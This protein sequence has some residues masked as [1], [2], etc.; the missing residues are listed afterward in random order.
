MKKIYSILIMSILLSACGTSS[1]VQQ[2]K[3]PETPNFQANKVLVI[4]MGSDAVLRR[5]FEGKLV[6]ALEKKGVIAVKSVDFF[7][8]SFT[9]LKQSEAQLNEIENTLMDAGFDAVLFSKV[10]G[11]ESK[12]S[13]V[14][15]YHNFAKSFE[16][17][18]DYYYNNQQIYQKEQSPEYRIYNTETSLYCICPGKERELLWRGQIDIVAPTKAQKSI[19]D[20]I[21][22]LLSAL[23]E[24]HILIIP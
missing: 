9:N 12:V 19:R 18:R 20:Y 15:S 5:E 13:M 17:F 7:P 11:Q 1:L 6:E 8:S 3:S 10:T 16:S 2:W 4:G 21:K 22:T 14:Q 24:N 23:Q